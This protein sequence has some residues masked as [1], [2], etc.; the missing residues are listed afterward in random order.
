M[1][2]YITCY[3]DASGIELCNSDYNIVIHDLK[4]LRGVK[5]RLYSPK[6]YDWWRKARLNKGLILRIYRGNTLIEEIKPDIKEVMIKWFITL[7]NRA[8]IGDSE[9]NN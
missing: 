2:W 1:K 8:W 4:T 5:N 7:K 9:R 6:R 3:D